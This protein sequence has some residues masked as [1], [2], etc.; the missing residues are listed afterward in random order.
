[1]AKLPQDYDFT[2]FKDKEEKVFRVNS[3]EDGSFVIPDEPFCITDKIKVN[4]ITDCVKNAPVQELTEELY[5]YITENS[6]DNCHFYLKYKGYP[7][8]EQ[9]CVTVTEDGRYIT[10]QQ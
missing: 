4:K 7:L 6:W 10:V 8:T 3:S 1:M 9:F 2:Y 5:N